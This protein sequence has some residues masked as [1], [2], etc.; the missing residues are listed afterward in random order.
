MKLAHR[1]KSIASLSSKD[2]SSSKAHTSWRK[3]FFH[4][5]KT[6]YHQLYAIYVITG[7]V[8]LCS[9]IWEGSEWYLFP[10]TDIWANFPNPE[11]W[12]Y[13]TKFVV[14]FLMLWIDDFQLF[15]IYEPSE[16][17]RAAIAEANAAPRP[18]GEDQSSDLSFPEKKAAALSVPSSPQ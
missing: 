1:K 10:S 16:E 7:Y 4:T 13:L 5:F 12:R 15:E 14:G 9:A 2:L 8:L 11:D 6:K 17:E 18:Q 3:R